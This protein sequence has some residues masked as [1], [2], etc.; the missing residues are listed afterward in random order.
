[1]IVFQITFYYLSDKLFHSFVSSL[2]SF[3]HKVCEQQVV[4]ESTTFC[5]RQNLNFEFTSFNFPT[6]EKLLDLNNFSV[7]VIKP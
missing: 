7:I 2:T 5:M 3:D 1:M 4:G 6:V